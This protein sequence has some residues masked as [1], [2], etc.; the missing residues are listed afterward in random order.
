MSITAILCWTTIVL[1]GAACW[2]FGKPIE[3][4]PK[5]KTMRGIASYY[6]DE[7]ANRPMANG[8]PYDP[9]KYTAASWVYPLGSMVKVTAKK[10]GLSVYVE[11]T[12][13]GPAR[14]LNRVID[15]SRTAFHSIGALRD[16][17]IDVTVEGVL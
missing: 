6:S 12:D 11:I 13:R 15:L 1:F 2:L 5:T 9:A 10:T 16:G 8:R 17:L 14:R 4:A 7:L 3:G